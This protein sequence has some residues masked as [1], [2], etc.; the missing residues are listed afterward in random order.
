MRLRTLRRICVVLTVGM[1]CCLA[2]PARGQR[3]QLAGSAAQIPS[4]A[5]IQPAELNRML[6]K[7]DASRPLILQVGSR[8]MFEE[9]HI[10]GSEYAGPGSQE[11][12]LDLLK[13]RVAALGHGT[14][15]VIY[16]GCCPW[17]R[18]PNIWPAYKTLHDMGFTHVRALYLA[19]NFGTNWVNKGYPVEKSR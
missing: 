2:A 9:A 14:P 13:K 4:A 5:L 18:C 19:D 15:I 6:N 17:S 11:A 1:L 3:A 7:K 12:G 10:S 8:L 16:C